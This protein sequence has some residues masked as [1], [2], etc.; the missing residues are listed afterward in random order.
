M[1]RAFDQLVINNALAN[2]NVV[3]CLDRA[4]LV[5]DDGP[6]HHGVFDIVYGRMVPGVRMMAPSD[7]AELVHM[8]HTALALEGP[9]ILRWPRGEA[10]GRR[11]SRCAPGT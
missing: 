8:L 3:F 7:E 2:T 1:Q 10:R 6:T 4:G 11:A 5:G 9:V